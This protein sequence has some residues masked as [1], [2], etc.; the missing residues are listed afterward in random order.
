MASIIC[1]IG[2]SSRIL[3]HGI[4]TELLDCSPFLQLSQRDMFLP[5]QFRRSLAYRGRSRLLQVTPVSEAR[6][7]NHLTSNATPSPWGLKI[8]FLFHHF[9]WAW[10]KRTL[11]TYLASK[12][13]HRT[14]CKNREKPLN[15]NK[16]MSHV[17][18]Y[19]SFPVNANSSCLVRNRSHLERII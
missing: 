11:R 15:S 9:V 19:T 6:N 10:S 2:P 18:G 14:P 5:A 17:N 7:S 8:L 4:N 16:N 13:P 1:E 12:S 3:R